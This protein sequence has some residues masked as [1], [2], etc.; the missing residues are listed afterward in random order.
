[1]WWIGPNVLQKKTPFL[2][3]LTLSFF[4]VKLQKVIQKNIDDNLTIIF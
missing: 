2:K 3:D 1:M 4:L